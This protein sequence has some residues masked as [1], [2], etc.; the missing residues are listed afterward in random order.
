MARPARNIIFVPALILLLS[1][2]AALAQTPPAPVHKH[3]DTPAQA[4]APAAGQPLAPRLQNLG[5][6]TF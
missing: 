6:H 3:Y 1:S 2:T 5:V 4:P